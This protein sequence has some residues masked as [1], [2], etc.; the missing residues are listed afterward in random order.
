MISVD[1]VSFAFDTH[2]VLDGISLEVEPGELVGMI[3]PNGAGK[4]T[5][6]RLI[7]GILTPDTGEIE[8]DGTPVAALSSKDLSRRV[9]VVPQHTTLSFDFSIRD[10]V[11]MGRHPYTGRFDRIGPSERQLVEAAMY[12]THVHDLAER[13]FSEVSGGERKRVLIARAIAQ[14]TPAMLVD[15][16]TASLDINHQLAVF[17]LLE[18]LVADEKAI[19]AAIHDL[20]LAARYCDRLLLLDRGSIVAAGDPAEVLTPDLLHTAYGVETSIEENPVTG[21]PLVVAHR[22]NRG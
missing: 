6:L 15:E 1:E 18:E 11:A 12:R 14:E 22:R 5:L 21:T 9:A 16:P 13:P 19:L 8:L 20:D 2:P 17:E 7:D 3:G 10:V 4:T